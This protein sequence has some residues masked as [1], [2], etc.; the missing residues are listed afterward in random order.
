MNVKTNESIRFIADEE[1]SHSYDYGTEFRDGIPVVADD[2]SYN[3]HGGRD[4][5]AKLSPARGKIP[6][7]V[8]RKP[9]KEQ[10]ENKLRLKL[11]Q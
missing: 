3:I 11:H 5:F 1:L 7:P 4:M 6:P 9:S 2:T 8:A 10:V